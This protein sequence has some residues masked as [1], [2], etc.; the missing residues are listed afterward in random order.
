MNKAGGSNYPSDCDISSLSGRGS[1]NC[2]QNRLWVQP[3]I[4]WHVNLCIEFVLPGL[5]AS[6]HNTSVVQRQGASCGSFPSPKCL[7]WFEWCM[8]RPSN[9]EWLNT[10]LQSYWPYLDKATK[11][12]WDLRQCPYSGIWDILGTA[13]F[14]R[15]SPAEGLL[16]MYIRWVRYCW[17]ISLFI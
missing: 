7:C 1:V 17:L 10:D 8:Y 3:G 9:L 4:P 16:R 5:S 6:P 12:F 13:D 11:F 15:M 14:H 2:R